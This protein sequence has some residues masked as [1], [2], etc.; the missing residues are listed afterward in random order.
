[1]LFSSLFWKPQDCFSVSH[2]SCSASSTFTSVNILLN[3]VQRGTMCKALRL[4]QTLHFLFK[5]NKYVHLSY[6]SQPYFEED[7]SQLPLCLSH[8]CCAITII[9]RKLHCS[10]NTCWTQTISVIASIY[11]EQNMH[12]LI[13][14]AF[15]WN[16]IAFLF[17]W[18]MPLKMLCQSA[19]LIF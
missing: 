1:M 16:N 11:R 17:N 9:G 3:A 18:N 5:K 8:S 15:L 10:T 7:I 14:P 13:L 12:S 6:W 4:H 2:C 19:I